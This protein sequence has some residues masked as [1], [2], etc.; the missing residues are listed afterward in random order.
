[1]LAI[2]KKEVKSYFIS[3]IGYAFIA[4]LL[5]VIGLVFYM[6]N[7]QNKSPFIGYAL[8]SPYVAMVMMVLVPVVTM[9]IFADE[10]HTR[11]DQL[12]FTAPV[13]IKA[14]V[15]GKFLAAATIFTIPMLLV[16]IY[17]MILSEYG[18]VPMATSYVAILGFYLMGLAYFAIGIFI[19]SI[20]ENQFISAVATFAV[21]L[22]TFMIRFMANAIPASDTLSLIGYIVIAA[23]TGLCYYILTKNHKSSIIKS[24]TIFAV[25]TAIIIVAYLLKAPIFEN[26][27]QNIMLFL[28]LDYMYSD[29]TGQYLDLSAVFYYVSVIGFFTFLTV[30]SIQKRRWS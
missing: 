13:T 9:K 15:I 14:I 12:L 11:S 21:L 10:R 6:I 20:T 1:M 22:G 27:I 7:V 2:Y 18:I 16:L 17:P 3:M 4:F 8:E 30:Q 23:I 25:L 19:S 26:A 29:F 24:L 28:S 5:L